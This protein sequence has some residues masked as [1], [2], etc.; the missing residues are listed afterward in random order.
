MA[1]KRDYYEV[2]SVG[3]NTTEDEIKK[4]YR[5]LAIK[6]HPDKN[7]GNEEAEESFK[8]A[9]E[10]YEVLR[11]SE[12]RARYDR[13]GHAG[14]QGPAGGAGADFGNFEDIVGDLFGDLGDVFGFGSSRGQSGPKR[15]RSL[16]YDLEISLEDV[17]RGKTVTIEVPRLETCTRCHGNGAEPES[18]LETCPDCHGRGQVTHSQGF[19]TM[20]RTCGRCRG[21]GRIIPHP[22]GACNGRGVSRATRKIKVGIPKGVDAGFKIQMRG[23][24][25]AGNSGG[26]P[27]DLFVVIH[28]IPHSTFTREENNLITSTKISF[29]QAALGGQTEV[30]TIDGT[31]ILTI[32][33]E[34]QYG[35]QFRLRG[36]GVPYYN[37]N[38]AGDLVVEVRI[39]TPT[40]LAP[41]EKE[42]L[43]EFAQLRGESL[44][45]GNDGFFDKLGDKLFH[46]NHDEDSDHK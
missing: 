5:K 34:T 30:T 10:A 2:L 13:Y 15:G 25:E 24:G 37:H 9:T 19:L 14:L 28:V 40:R 22:C 4:A 33:P 44:E 45:D 21:E 3:R 7:P 1:E 39:Q 46:R 41:R 43:V 12:K 29:I 6:Y 26:P 32:P 20:S 23:E 31:E 11:D 42:I 8:E 18:R 27:G 17:I 36:K 16:Q 38:G 35:Q